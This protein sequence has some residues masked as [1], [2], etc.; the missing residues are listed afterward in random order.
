M[1]EKIDSGWEG[2]IIL[3]VRMNTVFLSDYMKKEIDIFQRKR[4]EVTLHGLY[5]LPYIISGI[6]LS[7]SDGQEVGNFSS[8]EISRKT[9]KGNVTE[10][11]K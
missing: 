9:A 4:K 6:L 3:M 8:M 5:H 2:E 10:C 11:L 7:S 1:L